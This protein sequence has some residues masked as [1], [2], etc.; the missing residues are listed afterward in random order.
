MAAWRNWRGDELINQVNEAGKKSVNETLET[1]GAISDGQIPLDEG[2][3]KSSKT[4]KIEFKKNT[5]GSLSYGGGKGTGKPKIPYALKWHQ[6]QAN[7]Q[8][9]RKRF[10]LRDPFNK[11]APN[12]LN[13]SLRRNIGG[14]L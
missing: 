3:L 7:F 2:P 10:Y 13:A 8:H 14:V 1:V 9:G 12:L 5:K 11:F 4:I 6:K